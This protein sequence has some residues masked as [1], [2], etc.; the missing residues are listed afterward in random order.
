MKR[1]ILKKVLNDSTF[2]EATIPYLVGINEE[3]RL[4][5]VACS[6]FT[7]W[8]GREVNMSAG[9]LL[10]YHLDTLALM[11][12]IDNLDYPVNDIA[13]H[14]KEEVIII[15]TG[16]YDGGLYYEGELLLWE[17]TIEKIDSILQENR[18]IVTCNFAEDG[19]KLHFTVSPED[20]ESD[21]A[22]ERYVMDFP[23]DRHISLAELSPVS[24]I[25]YESDVFIK[26]VLDK[27]MK[28]VD[29]LAEISERHGKVYKN[30]HLIWDILFINAYEIAVATNN[31]IVE[32]W[33]LTNETCQEIIVGEKGKCVE[34]FFNQSNNTLLANLWRMDFNVE[35]N[36]CLFSIS[37]ADF[38]VKPVLACE[39][40]LSK[41][42]SDYFL[43]RNIEYSD[44]TK[45]DFI[46]NSDYEKV[47]EKRLGH[48][49]LFNHY[50]RI[51]QSD[52]LYFLAG[53]PPEQHQNKAL[54]SINPVNFEI[55][56][57]FS[58]EQQPNH[59]NSLNGIIVKDCLIIN[60]RVYTSD[61]NAYDTQ[62]LFCIDLKTGTEKWLR[63]LSSQVSAFG[64]L[65]KGVSVIMA[66]AEGGLEIINCQNG[67]TIE[68]IKRENNQ[69][70]SRPLSLSTF[71]DTIVVGLINGNIE[72]YER[73]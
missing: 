17:Y 66:M 46:L 39:A 5:A 37:L 73:I 20:D 13:F 40:S 34:L 24:A 45:K 7:Q 52:L 54:Y 21:Y 27:P 18:E 48:Y 28:A 33:H 70:F 1:T 6:F 22:E 38:E 63:T 64:I 31:G 26:K 65:D 57:V 11:N 36:S 68:M 10:L 4:I 69:T 44:K 29:L 16:R 61:R 49:D 14:P 47:F 43:V 12:Y 62:E 30:K 25:V 51:D 72:V 67:E 3:K 58:L 71:G 55:K 9:S 59:Y 60:A 19:K 42:L 35:E 50:L 56:E 32:I 53:N 23:I 41:N 2:S 15:G 8:Q